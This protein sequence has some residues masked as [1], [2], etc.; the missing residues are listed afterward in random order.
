M[1]DIAIL[2]D[3]LDANG[4][5]ERVAYEMARALDAPI[6]AMW[7]DTETTPEDIEVVKLSETVGD[8]GEALG[9]YGTY[10]HPRLRHAALR[11]VPF[12]R[13]TGLTEYA[14]DKAGDCTEPS[15]DGEGS[16]SER[17][18]QLGYLDDATASRAP[19][20]GGVTQT[21]D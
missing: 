20:R 18:H 16:V 13:V 5:A 3:Q 12:A 11:V 15:R 21:N 14:R 9:E 6:Y 4:G 1:S 19:D 17:L 7:A 10:A 8:H 2:H